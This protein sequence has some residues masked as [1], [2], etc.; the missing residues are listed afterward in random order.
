[1]IHINIWCDCP[2]DYF[3]RSK[4]INND[5]YE[6]Y[7]TEKLALQIPALYHTDKTPLQS[8]PYKNPPYPFKTLVHP[9]PK[10]VYSS[11]SP[12]THPPT[13]S[14]S[15]AHSKAAEVTAIHIYVLARYGSAKRSKG[16][17]RRARKAKLNARAGRRSLLLSGGR[18]L[19]YFGL[20]SLRAYISSIYTCI[21]EREIPFT[22]PRA[23]EPLCASGEARA[24][25]AS[26]DLFECAQAVRWAIGM[27]YKYVCVCVCIREWKSWVRRKEI[28]K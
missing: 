23:S 16:K 6:I 12:L 17:F 3:W 8:L 18:I 10:K 21:V 25:R 5:Q 28:Q 22:R 13:H 11:I 20:E 7:H 9:Y 27:W 19:N 24:K 15:L 14:T 1:M 4:T 2:Q 26:I